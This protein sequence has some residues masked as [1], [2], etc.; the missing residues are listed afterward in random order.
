M[1]PAPPRP[2]PGVALLLG[3]LAVLAAGASFIS[4]DDGVG[5]ALLRAVGLAEPASEGGSGSGGMPAYLFPVSVTT[6]APG[7]VE[8]TVSLVGDVLSNR[9]AEL[10]FERSGRVAQVFADLGDEVEQGALLARLDDAVLERE[11][12]VARAAAGAAEALARNARRE[13]VRANDVGDDILSASDRDRRN[14]DAEVAEHRA[15]QALADV[16]RLTALLAQGELR[17]PFAG[18]VTRRLVTDGSHATPGA[19]AYVLADLERRDVHLELPE[20]VAAALPADVRVL[21]SLD[22]RPELSLAARIDRLVPAADLGTRSFTAVVHLA[23]LDPERQ[24]LP[25]MFVR[26]RLVL[27]AVDADLVVPVDA[28]QGPPDARWI[29]VADPAEAAA[30]SA[31]PGGGGAS[32]GD[33][34]PSGAPPVARFVPVT[35]LARDAQFAAI[36]PRDPASLPASPSVVVTGADNVFPGAPL[37]TVPHAAPQAEHGAGAP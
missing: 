12:E 22:A 27:Q 14:A 31:T 36:A 21:L 16:A 7:H 28:L 4:W 8:E 5:A 13:A 29:V 18:A 32:A 24:L 15:A 23:G 26:A 1:T 30:D 10:A 37:R 2:S 20:P 35:V 17:A 6:A 19:P 9:W 33:A 34:A 25:G 11:I 3:L